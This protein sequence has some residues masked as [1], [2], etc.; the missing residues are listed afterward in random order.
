[1]SV[2]S[3]TSDN[4]DDLAKMLAAFTYFLMGSLF[5]FE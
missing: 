3:I 2:C 5:G 4:F 1:M